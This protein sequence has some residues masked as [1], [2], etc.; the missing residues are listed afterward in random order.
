MLKGR[1]LLLHEDNQSIIRVI[2]VMCELR[3]LF[4]LIDTYDIKIMTHYIRSAANV[5]A[6][7]MSRVTDNSNW[8]LAPRKF[9]HFD[10]KWR[11]HT[12]D[13]FASNANK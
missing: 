13:R 6:D 12:I 1:R 2:G 11:P 9:K 3:K 4:L 8:K 10:K 7:N 5:W